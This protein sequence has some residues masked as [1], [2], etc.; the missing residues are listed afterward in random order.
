VAAV[1]RYRVGLE[2]RERILSATRELL[3]EVGIE[4]VT[5]KAITDR[6]RVGAGSF[7]NLFETKEEAVLEVVREAITAVDP[8]P[9]EMGRESLE[10]LLEAYVAFITEDSSI[11]RIYLQLATSGFTDDR[12]AQRVRRSHR[13]RV[14]RFRDAILRED[15]ASTPDG[16]ERQ[17]EAIL[18]ALTGF[19]ITW[20]ID[21]RF[22]FSGQARQ[23]LRAPVGA[24]P[25]T[26]DPTATENAPTPVRLGARG[27]RRR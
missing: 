19:A 4:G 18:A 15:P 1:A 8:D 27:R 25:R 16:A 7:Y 3:G 22:D 9:A 6:A 24:R 14:E 23:L 26:A 10:E 17:A 13:R 2:T 20:F 5:L 21:E 12:M 11:A